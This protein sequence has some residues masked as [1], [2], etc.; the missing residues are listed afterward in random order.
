MVADVVVRGYV[1]GYRIL[2]GLGSI[3]CMVDVESGGKMVDFL[4]V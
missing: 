3:L 1:I 2:R 4:F